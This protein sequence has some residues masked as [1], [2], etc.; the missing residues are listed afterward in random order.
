MLIETGDWFDLP[1]KARAPRPLWAIGDIHGCTEELGALHDFLRETVREPGLLVYLGD[2]V[3]RGRDSPGALSMVRAGP[4]VEGLETLALRGNHDQ[5]L[6]DAAGLEG[7][8]EPRHFENWAAWGGR[9]TMAD[10]ATDPALDAEARAASLRASLGP[11]RIAFLLST[12]LTHREGDI[13]FVHA[14][15]NPARRLDEQ[16]P[17]DLMFVRKDFVGLKPKEWPFDPLVVH[18]HT[19]AALG[20]DHYRIG[21]D[22]RCFDTGTLTLLEMRGRRGRF[23]RAMSWKSPRPKA[24]T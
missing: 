16:T 9:T 20:V 2:Y 12:V 21:V 5:Y 15:L 23:H 10:L 4:G 7:R 11:E 8:I 22:S 13:L 14:G 3:D 1:R 17:D 19:P 6:I 18:G 24:R